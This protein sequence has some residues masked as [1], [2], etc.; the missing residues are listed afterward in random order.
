MPESNKAFDFQQVLRTL[1][2]NPGNLW[3][4]LGVAAIGILLLLSG[5]GREG[6]VKKTP[7]SQEISTP[8]EPG[9]IVQT[10]QRLESELEHTLSQIAGVGDVSVKIHL[11]SGSRRIWERQSHITRRS[12]Q[13][14]NQVDSE[15]SNSDEMVLANGKDGADQPVLRE[16]LAPE[17]DGVLIVATGAGDPRVKQVLAET[18][19]TI[20]QLPAHRV[21]VTAGSGKEYKK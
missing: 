11:K 15:E 10:E 21:M 16:E 6:E 2:Q 12:Q 20:L 4:L 8:N 14:Q 7:V 1:R 19:M 17:V 3:I 13:Q 9:G 5:N 18:V